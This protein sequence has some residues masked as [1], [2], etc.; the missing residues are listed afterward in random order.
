[1]RFWFGVQAANRLGFAA[2]SGALRPKH[3]HTANAGRSRVASCFVCLYSKSRT[4]T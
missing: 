2:A 1:M 3:A 4:Q